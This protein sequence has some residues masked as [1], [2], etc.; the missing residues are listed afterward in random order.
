MAGGRLF[1][2]TRG[3][4]PSALGAVLQG[5]RVEIAHKPAVELGQSTGLYTIA[6]TEDHWIEA[7]WALLS[8]N[9]ERL[10]RSAESAC[11]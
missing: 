8:G 9:V 1:P 7:Q 11:G 5:H 10:A 3:A 6:I 2:Q 4:A